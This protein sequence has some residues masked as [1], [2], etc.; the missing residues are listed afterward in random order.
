[1][2]LPID[3]AHVIFKSRTFEY[4]FTKEILRDVHYMTCTVFFFPFEMVPG[5]VSYLDPLLDCGV[6]E[7]NVTRST[8]TLLNFN[9][10]PMPTN[11][12]TLKVYKL[13]PL[14]FLNTL[15]FINT[16]LPCFFRAAV[17]IQW[18][19]LKNVPIQLNLDEIR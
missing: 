15:L 11:F 8:V 10:I 16:V 19:K 1:M 13:L 14:P 5:Y 18:T 6:T 17:R 4:L 9:T 2:F 7:Y 3:I 12:L